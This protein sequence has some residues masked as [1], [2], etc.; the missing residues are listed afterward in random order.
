MKK[1]KNDSVQSFELYLNTPKG[2]EIKFLVPKEVV[3]VPDSYISD[4]ITTLQKRRHITLTS[5]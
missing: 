3:V 1:I 2:V 5:C 4:Q